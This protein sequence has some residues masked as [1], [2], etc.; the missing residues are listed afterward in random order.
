MKVDMYNELK[1]IER[2]LEDCGVGNLHYKTSTTLARTRQLRGYRF[3]LDPQTQKR[4]VNKNKSKE[5][6]ETSIRFK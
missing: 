5:E 4:K 6:E 2:N 1:K 3:H